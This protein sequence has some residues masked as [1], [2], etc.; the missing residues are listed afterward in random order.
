MDENGNI[1]CSPEQYKSAI[2]NLMQFTDEELADPQKELEALLI[3][4]SIYN[5]EKLLLETVFNS[6]IKYH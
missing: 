3:A 6:H 5:Y 2:I 1:I 4:K